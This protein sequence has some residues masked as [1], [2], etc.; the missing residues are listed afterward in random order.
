MKYN[1]ALGFILC[2]TGFLLLTT[3]HAKLATWLGGI[4]A[5]LG[6]VTLSEYL[7]DRDL[8]I[9]QIFF[10]C[11]I[12]TATQFS[13]RMSQL[14]ASCFTL[15][16]IALVLTG[17]SHQSKGRLTAI[18]ILACIV[19]VIASVALAGYTL[20][21]EAA[22]GWGAYTRLALHTATTFLIL[23]MGLLG[24]ARHSADLIRFDFTRWLPVA[25]SATLLAMIGVISIVSFAE[26]RSATAWREHSS[27]VLTETQT[28][29]GYLLDSQ[30]GMRGYVLTGQPS[31]LTVYQSGITGI[32]ERLA[33]LKTLTRDN[34]AQQ[35]RL[36]S[37]AADVDKTI[38]YSH[39]LIDARNAKGLQ[40]SVALE[41]TGEG[42]AVINH[43]VADLNAFTDAE[44]ELLKERAA[45]ARK[46]FNNLGRLLIFDCGWA[47]LLLIVANL[48]ANRELRFRRRAERQLQEDI[49][50]RKKTEQTLRA[51]EERFRLI[52]DAVKDYALLMLDPKGY[53]VSWNAGAERIKG[54]RAAEIIGKH[55]SCFYLPKAIAEGHPEE[56]LRLA[57]R[58]GRYE[59]EG[60][61]VRKDGS[62]FLANVIITAIQDDD[63]KLRGFAKITRDITEKRKHEEALRLSEERFTNAFEHA[64]IGMALLSLDG[65]WLK[66]NQALCDLTGY[67]HEELIDKN[68][69][70]ITHPDD[71]E[72]GYENRLLL[73]TGKVRSSCMEKRYIHKLGHPVWVLLSRSLIHD[74]Q[75][76]PLHF[77]SQIQDITESKQ[78]MARQVELTEKAQAAE[79]AKSEFLAVMSHEIRTPMNGVIGMT[80]ILADMELTEAQRDCVDT[81]HSSGESLLTVINDIL[82]YSKIEAGKMQL[83]STSFSLH[84]CVEEA[85]DLFAAQIR[86]NHLEAAYLVASDIPPSLIG[87]P[88]RLRQV[89]VNL[90]GNAIKFTATG[91]I[92]INVECQNHDEAGY[93]LLFSVTDT[94]IGISREGIE[95]LFQAFQQADTSTTRR[96]GGTGLGLAIS[97]RIVELMGGKMWVESELG[98]G[99]TFFFSVVMKASP[100]PAPASQ[101]NEPS[102]LKSHSVLIVDDNNTNRRILETQLKI[103][104]MTPTAVSSGKKALKKIA[105]QSFDVAL[106]DYQMFEMDGVTLAKEVRKRTQ[107]PLI[108]LSSSGEIVVGE[109]AKLFQFQISKPIKHSSLFNALLRVVG[110]AGNQM[111]KPQEKKLDSELAIKRPLHILLAEDN[112]VNQKV[113][114]TMLSRL[115]YTADL[116]ANGHRALEAIEKARYDLILMDIQMPEMNGIEAT[117]LIREK[118]GRECPVIFALTAEALEGDKEKFLHLGFDGYLSKPLQAPALQDMLK[119]LKTR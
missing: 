116:A 15:L 28:F 107:T 83:E 89:M 39:R 20:G 27:Q 30:R 5:L 95:K 38:A 88:M 36:E 8:G 32:S 21:I 29:L 10:N 44:H 24:W 14:A 80:S 53:V 49:A 100:E 81:I 46:D 104:G 43:T 47:A 103:W 86:I 82:D 74:D 87:D 99:S 70:D 73:L 113:G 90:I 67:T 17:K 11:Y 85:L 101:V 102:L 2:G 54:Y 34:P 78:A 110:V 56:E 19:A 58:E 77:I 37:L 51:S 55:F 40:A 109:E 96:Y 119:A 98:R 112:T 18:G 65:R 68:F 91:E 25:G 7:I 63:G 35:A 84:Q 114:L 26:L 108:L 6:I 33:K 69:Q 59:E 45:L 93:H 4:V 60:W 22:S 94:G 52:A 66:V 16:G 23:S 41:I 97:K 105:E 111:Q 1:T 115:G 48:M 72:I 117:T 42:F 118:L 62:L 12:D 75:N 79:R 13:G 76:H 57:A 50:K 64:P 31:A 92:V 106:L 71:L 61:R 3:R 9:D